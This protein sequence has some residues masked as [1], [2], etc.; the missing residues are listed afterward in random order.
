[1]G[2]EVTG[3]AANS[4]FA[5][6]ELSGKVSKDLQIHYRSFHRRETSSHPTTKRPVFGV[7]EFREPPALGI[8]APE[9]TDG[10][11]RVHVRW[12]VKD[13]IGNSI[14]SNSADDPAVEALDT[15]RLDLQVLQCVL[16]KTTGEGRSRV[17]N[18]DGGRVDVV[19]NDPPGLAGVVAICCGDEVSD[20]PRNKDR[21]VGRGHGKEGWKRGR[22]RR[23]RGRRRRGRRG[24]RL[25]RR[26]RR[27]G[28]LTD[29]L[30]GTNNSI[31]TRR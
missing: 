12:E 20:W 2:V 1:M 7:R 14:T 28:A 19:D 22:Q 15:C 11:Q 27:D 21:S 8:V 9:L 30:R 4:V 10:D 23:S 31:C 3:R 24:E 26:D 16:Q 18:G 17:G 5:E 29:G 25:V 6:V 13:G